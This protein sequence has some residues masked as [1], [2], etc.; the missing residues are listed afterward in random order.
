[1][2]AL[3]FFHVR[4]MNV[5]LINKNNFLIIAVSKRDEMRYSIKFFVFSF[6]SSR[7]EVFCEKVVLRNFTK[8][9]GKHLCQSFFF[10]KSYFFKTDTLAQIFSCEFSEIYKNT[11]S[12]RTP[13]VA[14]SI[15]CFAASTY[16]IIIWVSRILVAYASSTAYLLTKL[17]HA[18]LFN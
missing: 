5:K 6:K 13:R 2:G 14:V 18:G 10:N 15:A 8:L 4:V 17:P 7:P 11:F 16:V 12:Y 1:M 3:L 9:T